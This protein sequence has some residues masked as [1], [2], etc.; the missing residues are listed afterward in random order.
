MCPY[1]PIL[2]HIVHLFKIQN[3]FCNFLSIL[4]FD[5]ITLMVISR[6]ERSG[7]AHFNI[8][9]MTYQFTA[10]PLTLFSNTEVL[11]NCIAPCSFCKVVLMLVTENIMTNKSYDESFMQ[12]IY[13]M[14]YML[15][16]QGVFHRPTMLWLTLIINN[17]RKSYMACQ[18]TFGPLTLDYI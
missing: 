15:I 14:S 11:T 1:S 16:Q 5:W 10:V 9:N 13:S 18:F 3:L 8:Y 17:Y 2:T 6:S 12:Y 4:A 7:L